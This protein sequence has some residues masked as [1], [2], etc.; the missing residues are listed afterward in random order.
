MGAKPRR[1]TLIGPTLIVAAVVLG[2]GSIVNA[3]KVGCGD[4]YDYLWVVPLAGGLMLAMTVAAIRFGVLSDSTILDQVARRA[5]RIPAILVGGC[6][7]IAITLFQAS[8]NHALLMARDGLVG[9]GLTTKFGVPGVLVD[10]A[11]L[12]GFNAMVIGL[13]LAQRAS[14][15]S[16]IE[17]AMAWLVAGMLLAFLYCCLTL[18]PSPAELWGGLVPGRWT[19]G[20]VAE[21]ASPVTDSSTI[22]WMS[23][24]ALV[25]TTFSVAGAFY[26]TYQGRHKG[27]TDRDLPSTTRDAAVGIGALVA[28]TLLLVITAAAGLH[29]RVDPGELDSA[30]AVAQ[31][32]SSMGRYATPVF[33]FGVLAGALS[34]FVVN[35]LIGG[36]VACDAVGASTDLGGSPVRRATT[37][38]LMIGA[39]VSLVATVT[40]VNLIRFIVIAQSLTVFTYPVLA[41]VIGWAYWR[42]KDPVR[43]PIRAGI[44]VGVAAGFLV[45]VFLSIRTLSRL[46]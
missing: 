1:W 39:V 7:L 20:A 37:V 32:L 10:A 14:L 18:G 29:G 41:A 5:G 33:S 21:P 36:V 43:R 46:L 8:N 11:L 23:L 12:I 3:S 24:A 9:D 22:G 13:L 38:V 42:C 31:Q 28:T 16:R 4:G 45:T 19:T 25:A 2:P 17:K 34:S 30:M 35:A 15:Y 27:W 40:G 44:L 6:L 26:Q